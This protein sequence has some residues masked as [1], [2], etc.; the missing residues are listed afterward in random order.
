MTFF[1]N[2]DQTPLSP[3]RLYI[4]HSNISIYDAKA[5]Y[6]VEHSFQKVQYKALTWFK[7]LLVSTTTLRGWIWVICWS[8]VCLPGALFGGDKSCL[9]WEPT[10]WAFG[11]SWKKI[12]TLPM[13]G[14]KGDLWDW[15]KKM[16]DIKNQTEKN[17]WRRQSLDDLHFYVDLQFQQQELLWGPSHLLAVQ[18]KQ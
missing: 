6:L 15:T 12:V 2:T 16:H 17:C 7:A 9:F 11:K 13:F 8:V 18:L 3:R 14:K 10:N 5:C 1:L 4:T